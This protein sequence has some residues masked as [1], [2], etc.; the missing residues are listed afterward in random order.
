MV[1]MGADDPLPSKYF[2]FEG[3][4]YWI[5]A[6]E[7]PRSTWREHTLDCV[8]V[9]IGL[10]AR[11]YIEW[12]TRSGSPGHREVSGNG[13][14]I[15]PPG[16]PSR[17]LWLRR[18]ILVSI[19]LSKSF[20]S[21]TGRALHETRFDLE[22]VHLA[23]DPLIEELGRALYRECEMQELYKPFANSVAEVLATHLLR[24]YNA[25]AEL[26]S[27]FGIGLG[28][29]RNRRVRKYIEQSLERDL[30]IGALAKV[31]GLSPSYFAEMFRQ[32]TGFTPHQYV[33][34][35]R[36]DRARQLLTDRDLPLAEVAHRCGFTSQ[37][38]FTT[39]FH[40]FTGVTPG[41][42]RSEYATS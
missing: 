27:D 9:S 21:A 42:F 33:C 30:S 38:Q 37:S 13:V 15:I 14:A 40:R 25:S 26:L 10:E 23:R 29:A 39:V 36:V 12:R 17:T 24:N 20:L 6:A 28:P 2:W 7:Q 32:T 11:A 1:L 16:E 31:A 4:G 34:H 18:A 3:D 19:F 22:P 35:R 5:Y 41:R 8:R